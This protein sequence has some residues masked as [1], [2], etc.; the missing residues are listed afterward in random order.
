MPWRPVVHDLTCVPRT[1]RQREVTSTT[2]QTIG[3]TCAGVFQ[4][5]VQAVGLD[6]LDHVADVDHVAAQ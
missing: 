5:P 2:G 1:L 4:G 6:H 3:P